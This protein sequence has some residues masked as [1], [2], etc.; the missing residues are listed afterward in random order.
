VL[1]AAA[2]G[3]CADLPARLRPR[4]VPPQAGA[5]PPA[6]I[7]TNWQSQPVSG[8]PPCHAAIARIGG[9]PYSLVTCLGPRSHS[10]FRGVCLFDAR[11]TAPLGSHHVPPP[12][13]LRRKSQD[14]L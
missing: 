2:L 6:E 4:S 5:D 14:P 13:G 7:G 3:L 12:P 10:R 8:Q 11:I 9:G 1:A